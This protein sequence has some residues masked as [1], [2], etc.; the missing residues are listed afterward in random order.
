MKTSFTNKIISSHI[1]SIYWS[2]RG[3]MNQTHNGYTWNFLLSALQKNDIV[4]LRE[5]LKRDKSLMFLNKLGITAS[6]QNPISKEAIDLFLEYGMDVNYETKAQESMLSVAINKGDLNIVRHLL[7]KGANKNILHFS[8]FMFIILYG[9]NEQLESARTNTY[10]DISHRGLWSLTPLLLAIQGGDINKVKIVLSAGAN[11][12]ERG[13][14]DQRPLFYAVRGN[15]LPMVKFLIEQGANAFDEDE[16]SVTYLMS[17]AE[18]NASECIQFFIDL[19][20]DIHKQDFVQSTALN[21]CNT[22]DS[23][24]RLIE[25]GADINYIDGQGYSLLMSA[26]EDN[27]IPLLKYLLTAGADPNVSSTGVIALHHATK[28]NSLEAMK[29]LLD[30]GSNPSQPDVDKWTPLHA[31]HSI[32]AAEIL[33]RAGANKKHRNYS[34]ETPADN[35]RRSKELRDFITNW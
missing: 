25:A 1:S 7:D 4:T 5:Y 12:D 30:A 16:D 17:A 34:G 13:H 29:I 6:Y 11:L 28:S 23:A 18:H 33:L 3:F 20:L 32:E 19:G 35:A 22:I 24:K 15:H 14:C 21:Y 27:N 8:P 2:N 9:T 10:V 31:A 26:A